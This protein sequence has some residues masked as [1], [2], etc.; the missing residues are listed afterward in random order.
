MP[1][2]ISGY[3]CPIDETTEENLEGYKLKDATKDFEKQYIIKCMERNE[4]NVS[5]AAQE[6]GLARKNLYKKLKEYEIT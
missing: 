6:L 1:D 2:E 4:W 3:K 5:R